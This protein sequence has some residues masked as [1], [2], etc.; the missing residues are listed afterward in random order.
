[1]I[2]MYRSRTSAKLMLSLAVVAA[3]GVL[4]TA[5]VQAGGPSYHDYGTASEF[6]DVPVPEAND[7]NAAGTIS[8]TVGDML[9]SECQPCKPACLQHGCGGCGCVDWSAIP[10]SLTKMPRPGNFPNPPNAPG[11][12]TA[13][14]WITGNCQEK[15]PASGYP[16]FGL[17]PPSL[18]DADFRYVDGKPAEKRTVV[19]M[20]KR[21]Q[22]ND[23]MMF[24]TGGNA[25]VRYMKEQNSRLT[26]VE[27][28]YALTRVR[29]FGDLMIGDVARVYGEYLW[30]DSINSELPPSPVDEDLG[31]ILNLFVDVNLLEWDNH[32]LVARVGR[33]E[34]LLG[35]QRLVSTLDWANMR[36]TFEG[37]RL[38]RRGEK[39]D[40]DAFWTEFVP[41][42]AT[43]FD[44]ADENQ[45][46]AGAWLT[47]RPEP[48]E[49]LDFYY[50]F[51]N[52]ENNIARQDI[53]Q[54][55]FEAHTL[56]SR[57][58]GDECGWLW[59][60]EGAVQFGDA[61]GHDL[62][63]GAGTAGLGRHMTQMWGKPTAWVYYDYA[64][65]DSDPG[66]GDRHTFNDLYPF[67]HYYLG[68]ADLV[69]RRNIQ[70]ANAHLFLY[71]TQWTTVWLQYHHFWLA[72]SRDAL[73][74]AGGVPIRRD[75]T[76]QA[77]KNVGDEIDVVVNFHLTNY[78]DLMLGYSRLFG[79]GFLEGTSG[80]N[81]AV[82]S[83]V[84]HFMYQVKW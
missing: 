62:L 39:W 57:W 19:E 22:L 9:A 36:R 42:L 55:P 10:F 37:A 66:A 70:D 79:G 52:N 63:A 45:K 76:G 71:P 60:F 67:G 50:L 33:Q 7:D 24:S 38:F 2:S 68:W 17:M 56:G 80:P 18:F 51:L 5:G 73:Y 44:R 75:A 26:E 74:N 13:T 23:H 31:D 59:D 1:M 15:R 64:S 77:G 81:R 3:A 47:Y 28:S 40:I 61:G 54:A 29:V 14:D 6:D 12:F 43:E 41:A 16:P 58:T 65:G 46:F 11:Y 4:V 48:G 21:I 35:S 25:W 32:P 78:S 84:L 8:A 72:Q 82:D 30:A 27:N 20:L 34:L 69:G 53:V 49:F 83:D